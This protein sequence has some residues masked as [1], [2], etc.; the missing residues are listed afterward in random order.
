V[1][2]AV[3]TSAEPRDGIQGVARVEIATGGPLGVLERVARIDGVDDEI[4]FGVSPAWSS[5][6]GVAEDEFPPH[7]TTNDVFVASLASCL[8]AVYAGALRARGLSVQKGDLT[9]RVGY[10]IGPVP[11]SGSEW[12]IRTIHIVY[13]L[14]VADDSE[15]KTAIRVLGFYETGCPLSQTLKG[16]RCEITSAVEFE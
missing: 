14:N 10:D 2:I 15:R 8:L 3:G 6:Y 13:T 16:S 4:L 11:G 7:A 12:I 5:H 9:S 1:D